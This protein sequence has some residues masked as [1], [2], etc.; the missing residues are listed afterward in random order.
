MKGNAHPQT[1]GTMFAVVP[2]AFIG[3]QSIT[4]AKQRHFC[5]S[6]IPDPC[7]RA[8]KELSEAQLVCCDIL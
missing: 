5:S 1:L 2:A 3:L 6:N 8:G 4:Q 7:S